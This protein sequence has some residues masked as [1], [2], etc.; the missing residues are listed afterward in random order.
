MEFVKT[1]AAPPLSERATLQR[2]DEEWQQHAAA[3]IA[4][5]KL[6]DEAASALEAARAALIGLTSH[7]SESGAGG[8][9]HALLEG[10]ERRLQDGP[11]TERRRSRAI[12]GFTAVRD[13]HY[14][15]RLSPTGVV[16]EAM[17]APP[18]QAIWPSRLSSAGQMT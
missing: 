10:G 3:Y 9:G 18:P 1:D 8:H 11:G 6:A 7:S 2:G 16:I 5:K 12:P 13:A 15:Y 17:S 4:A 14:D